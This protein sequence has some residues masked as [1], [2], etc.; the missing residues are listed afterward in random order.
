MDYSFDH[1]YDKQK[2]FKFQQCNSVERLIST[3][4]PVLDK[5]GRL[6]II[7][8]GILE[9]PA[10]DVIVKGPELWVFD[11]KDGPRTAKLI[12]QYPFPA[13]VIQDGSGLS[14]LTVDIVNGNCEDT[15]IYIANQMDDRIVVYDFYKDKSWFFENYSFRGDAAESDFTFQ[16]YELQFKA[17]VSSITL[18]PIE[19]GPG[20]FRRVYYLAGSS[21][22]QYSVSTRELRNVENSPEIIEEL[23]EG[24]RG[25]DSQS[26]VHVIDEDTGVMFYA[27]TQT[28]RVRCWNTEKPLRPENL[29][30]IFES[31]G[32]I[33]GSHLSV[34]LVEMLK[35]KGFLI[36]FFF[37]IDF[38]GTL[39]F[40][41]NN[42]P[43][44]KADLNDSSQ[45]NIQL[46]R[47]S[48]KE[49]IKGTVC[50]SS[51]RSIALTKEN[52]KLFF[53]INITEV[54]TDDLLK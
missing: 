32:F 23:L 48:A 2:K 5:C 19:E 52:L 40:M 54:I 9:Y 11:V 39:W 27:E 14:G 22:G 4:Q 37:Q 49:I 43:L 7:D 18:G 6:W 15:F 51:R 34:S 26:M 45:Y 1:R 12:R 25:K 36:L 33:Y 21:T 29:G 13:D 41:S 17:G 53:N 3:Y 28:G 47:A 31:K 38:Q 42:F 44:F 10:G 20:G 35:N 24:Y 50:E 16:G 46:Y 8:T 30:T